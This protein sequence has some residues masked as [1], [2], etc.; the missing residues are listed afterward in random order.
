MFVPTLDAFAEI[1]KMDTT[2][3]FSPLKRIEGEGGN[4][5]DKR[6]I[7]RSQ[8][9]LRRKFQEGQLTATDS[10]KQIGKFIKRFG[11]RSAPLVEFQE[12]I[13]SSFDWRD[14]AIISKQLSAGEIAGGLPKTRQNLKTLTEF[15]K[16]EYNSWVLRKKL[17]Y[18]QETNWDLSIGGPLSILNSRTFQAFS[19]PAA[20][21][22][23][24]LNPFP[25]L[26]PLEFLTLGY[27]LQRVTQNNRMC[28]NV[29]IQ[30]KPSQVKTVFVEYYLLPNSQWPDKSAMWA[31]TPID[32]IKT[33]TERD[34]TPF[35]DTFTQY[36]SL[37]D[38]SENPRFASLNEDHMTVA[39]R[40][41]RSS[42]FLIA[43]FCCLS[44]RMRKDWKYWENVADQADFKYEDLVNDFRDF[45]RGVIPTCSTP[46]ENQQIVTP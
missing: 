29:A 9:N 4:E 33:F 40:Y 28:S 7:V 35:I 24:K 34:T 12:R 2:K 27:I 38:H 46:Q 18:D 45:E 5:A 30:E 3:W 17:Y 41:I 23:W 37:V 10:E 42:L 26:H 16:L 19:S 39:N 36:I 21:E 8:R 43:V 20:F 1:L 25:T 32:R 44:I 31:A 13:K 6:F 22:T 11:D 15:R 14:F